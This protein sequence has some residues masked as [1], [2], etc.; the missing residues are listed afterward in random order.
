[1]IF[2]KE[3]YSIYNRQDGTFEESSKE[4]LSH[5]SQFSMGNDIVDIN[6]DGYPE[7]FSLD[8]LP[9]KE[10]ILKSSTLNFSLNLLNL[11]RSLGYLDQFPRNH[12]QYNTGKNK[13]LEIAQFSGISAT[14]WSW[15]A[16]FNDLN[17]DSYQDL[18]VSNGI[19]RRPNDAD[20]IKYVSSEQI[21]TKMNLTK[22]IDNEALAKM[23]SG[24][25][26]NYVFEGR[27]D[28]IFVRSI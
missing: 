26:P 21:Q 13:F 14:D 6:H 27:K 25:M 16:L 11:K 10:E 17:L 18:F 2:L 12:L 28:L 4:F 22:L 3:I 15:S 24:S 9:E 23:P 20:Y 19:Y 7:I 5:T 8:M 1:M